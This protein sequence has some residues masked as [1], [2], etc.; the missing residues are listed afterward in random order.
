MVTKVDDS[1]AGVY[2]E[3]VTLST[4]R[5]I[6]MEL[7]QIADAYADEPPHVLIQRIA[8]LVAEYIE[9]ERMLREQGR[10]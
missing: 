6:V 4:P 7:R 10:G 9:H 2:R 8:A 5:S 1:A 3:R